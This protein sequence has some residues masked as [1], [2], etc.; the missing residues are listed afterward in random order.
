MTNFTAGS[1]QTIQREVDVP[2]VDQ[3][4]CQNQLRATR[5]GSSFQLDFNAFIC[6]GGEPGKGELSNFI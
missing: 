6:A 2:L 3:N 5:L 1:Y 4:A